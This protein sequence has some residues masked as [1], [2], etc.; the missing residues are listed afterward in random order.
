MY[1]NARPGPFGDAKNASISPSSSMSP[2]H[3][4]NDNFRAAQLKNNL[5]NVSINPTN[6]NQM[7]SYNN[8]NQNQNN[9]GGVSALYASKGKTNE[10]MMKGVDG[11]SNSSG[12]S[13][14]RLKG[15]APRIS[16]AAGQ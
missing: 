8:S 3:Q 2:G 14:W 4:L 15:D 16:R 12:S 6:T 13:F 5:T 10:E 9:M 1:V 7:V 11:A